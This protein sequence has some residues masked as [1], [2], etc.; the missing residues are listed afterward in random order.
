[1]PKKVR[2]VIHM[3]E[4]AGWR[5]VRTSGDHRIFQAQ[6]GR[7]TVVSGRLGSDVPAGTYRGIL[8]QTGLK[9]ET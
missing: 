5:H 9:E 7:T 8:K 2:E 1:M 6:D 4:R 3:L